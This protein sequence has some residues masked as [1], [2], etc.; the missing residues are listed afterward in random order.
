MRTMARR[1]AM[2]SPDDLDDGIIREHLT[3]E[4]ER[5]LRASGRPLPRRPDPHLEGENDTFVVLVSPLVGLAAPPTVEQVEAILAT[6]AAL[7]A[8]PGQCCHDTALLDMAVYCRPRWPAERALAAA[9][10]ERAGAGEML[11]RWR[12]E[13]QLADAVPLRSLSENVRQ[14]AQSATRRGA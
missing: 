14:A 7:A 2:D 13:W 11:A 6:H 12:R 5:M 1:S 3:E 4:E 9:L 8:R 10:L